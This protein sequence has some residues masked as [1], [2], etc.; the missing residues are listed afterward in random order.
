MDLDRSTNSSLNST[1]NRSFNSS[2]DAGCQAEFPDPTPRSAYWSEIHPVGYDSSITA[3][4]K[5]EPFPNPK[6]SRTASKNGINASL[7]KNSH[8][9][10]P[11]LVALV[12]GAGVVHFRNQTPEMTEN[13]DRKPEV[14]FEPVQAQPE[15]Q[16]ATMSL[17][18]EQKMDDMVGQIKA[19]IRLNEKRIEEK[20]D[21]FSGIEDKLDQMKIEQEKMEEKIEKRDLEKRAMDR[22]QNEAI[23]MLA[24]EGASNKETR[25]GIE[26]RLENLENELENLIS[27]FETQAGKLENIMGKHSREMVEIRGAV[28]QRSLASNLEN[29]DEGRW[30]LEEQIQGLRDDI[31]RLQADKTGMADYALE[32]TGAQ[33]LPGKL[34]YIHGL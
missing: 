1:G 26:K 14:I 33:I 24:R 4:E 18:C 32:A 7:R 28:Q 25:D 2:Q 16:L 20:L 22:L 21:F 10:Y 9:V 12:I 27:T 5:L 30:E 17:E 15:V 3:P 6:K 23:E 31:F 8:W 34:N 11:V 19:E 13:H 29:Q